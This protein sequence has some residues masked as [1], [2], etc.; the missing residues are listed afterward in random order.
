MSELDKIELYSLCL[1]ISALSE[2]HVITGTL[3]IQHVSID[4]GSAKL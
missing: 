3:S 1:Q 2:L 4:V